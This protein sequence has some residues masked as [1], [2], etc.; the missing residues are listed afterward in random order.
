[1][2]VLISTIVRNEFRYLDRYHAQ[3]RAIHERLGGQHTFLLSVFEND[4]ADGSGQKLASL[5]W[6]FLPAFHLTSAR[7]QTPPFIGGKHPIRTR[8]LADARNRSLYHCGFLGHADSVLVVEPD[9][10]LSPDVT[11]AIVNHE[12]RYGKRF[13]VFSG[14]STHVGQTQLYDSWG[15]RKTEQCTDWADGDQVQ[16]GGLEEIW[17]TFNCACFYRAKPIQEGHTFNGVNPRTKLPDCDT[18][19]IVEA[20]RLAGYRSVAWDR[21]LHVP[22]NCD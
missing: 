7:L 2:N 21:S 8:L 17:S 15:T 14:K 4:S 13:D 9:V 16:D 3:L 6:S 19:S 22:H 18:V 1:M 10:I 20:F 11:E 12:Q 5:D